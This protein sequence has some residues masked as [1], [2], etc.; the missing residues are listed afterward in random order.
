MLH[1]SEDYD[2][3][4]EKKKEEVSAAQWGTCSPFGFALGFCLFGSSFHL[5]KH[6]L[7]VRGN[8]FFFCILRILRKG[9]LCLCGIYNLSKIFGKD[10][11]VIKIVILKLCLLLYFYN[12]EG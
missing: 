5:G 9:K 2:I 12:L 6:R 1:G 11:S 3:R 7:A 10:K 8:F 4:A